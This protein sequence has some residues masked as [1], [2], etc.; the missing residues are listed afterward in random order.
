MTKKILV[1]L[2]TVGVVV[3]GVAVMSAFEAHV[4][5]VT[6]HIENAL[7]VDPQEIDFGVVFP[8]EYVEK[9]FTVKLSDSF[10][11]QDR[12][13][14]VYYKIVQ[15]PKP[16][17][18]DEFLYK[19]VVGNA[20]LNP[21]YTFINPTPADGSD[22]SILGGVLT[23]TAAPYDDLFGLPD[24]PPGHNYTAPRMLT[25]VT[26]DFTIETKVTA[27]PTQDYQGAGLLV[28]G[29]DGNLIRLELVNFG[30]FDR[31]I[32]MES[33]EN[34]VKVAKRWTGG[35]APNIPTEVYLRIT[36]TADQFNGYYSTD[37]TTWTE[38]P[39]AEGENPIV[40]ESIGD[41][42]QAGV[43]VTANGNTTGM[44]S[45]EFEYFKGGVYKDLCRFLSKLPK[46]EEDGDEGVLSYYVD[47][48]LDYCRNPGPHIAFG[49][50]EKTSDEED[51]WTVD[52]KVPPVEGYVGQDW[53]ESCADYTV[54]HDSLTYGCDLWI[55]VTELSY[56]QCSDGIDNDQD[57][58]IDEHDPGCHSDGNASNPASYVP[59]DDNET[60]D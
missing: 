27:I 40:N 10:C 45:A 53:P 13:H 14:D 33:Q 21:W 20:V 49:H 6:A 30:W 17:P 23:I 1:G 42:P 8:Q 46:E 4:I 18:N 39:Y 52:L 15:K 51:G 22:Y 41:R 19:D 32:Y 3:S 60:D 34:Y 25:G 9:Q 24:S 11:E 28:Y 38:V 26:G 59:N 50:L 35:E 56:W 16:L 57:Q 54:P 48:D 55:E 2:L 44:F 36:R 37:G 31:N 43:A 5:N 29:S 58:L 7:S 47:G 12:A